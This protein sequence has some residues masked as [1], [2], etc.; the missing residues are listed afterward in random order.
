MI[1]PFVHE[2]AASV[3]D[4]VD[5][6]ARGAT[7]YAGGTELVAAMK[8]GLLT[9][10]R[11][12][13]LKQVAEL[14]EIHVGSGEI[15]IGSTVPHAM[16]SAHG[17][18]RTRLP[19]LAQVTSEIGNARVR[20]Q[21][22]VGG[23]LCF[24]EPRSDLLPALIALGARLRLASSQGS[25]EVPADAFVIGPFTVDRR[26]DELLTEIVVPTDDLTFQHYERIQLLERPTA[27]V[28]LVG[29]PSGWRIVIGAAGY[30]PTW[31]DASSPSGFDVGAI[32]S[33]LEVMEDAA[34]SS[35]YKR[36]L[37]SVLVTRVLQLAEEAGG[38]RGT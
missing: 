5:A 19:M 7:P 36:Q 14:R 34:G 1:E 18:V 11:L 17:D 22:T 6:L 13:D 10:E 30:V 24:A 25:R 3:A 31:D 20:W 27:G 37:V 2:R 28:A 16:V 12:V 29:R 38:R 32:V 8:L 4:A 33:S 21:G 23:N 26:D 15:V 9:P 35:D